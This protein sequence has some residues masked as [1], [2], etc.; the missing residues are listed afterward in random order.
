MRI[1]SATAN[2][3]RPFLGRHRLGSRF[4]SG[5]ACLALASS[6]FG[7]GRL[8]FEQLF[9]KG[10]ASAFYGPAASEGHAHILEAVRRSTFAE[11][12][13]AMTQATIRL[14]HNLAIGFQ[15]CGTTNAFY[16][17]QRSSIVICLELL[18]L[19]AAQ[20]RSDKEF[21]MT[22]GKSEM[23][24]LLDGAVWGIFLHELAHAVIDINRVPITGREE[25]VADQFAVYF[26]H[27]VVE[28]TGMEVIL[29]TIWLFQSL[30]QTRNVSAELLQVKQ[31]MA[32]EHSM[33]AQ[34]TFNVACW[35]FGAGGSRGAD[36][37]R[38]VGLPVARQEKCPRE[39]AR[40]DE[41]LKARFQKFL[42]V[43]PGR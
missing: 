1:S 18:E 12:M 40:L 4:A 39:Y 34:R 3:F 20:A 36:A 10:Q 9:F 41:G 24:K 42:L 29:P 37:A 11:R 15:S 33:D 13:S 23:G 19:I 30:A 35:A 26:A 43:R 31:L 25:D 17:P 38:F 32:D 27:H 28:P 14:R 2:A 8:P 6:A 22:L 16:S 7:Q 5:I 21:A